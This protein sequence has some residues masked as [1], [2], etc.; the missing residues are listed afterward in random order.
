[1]SI[2]QRI[3]LFSGLILIIATFLVWGVLN[4]LVVEIKK[5]SFLAQEKIEELASL[6]KID[7]EYLRDL[8]SYYNNIKEDLSL[9]K[10]GFLD[11]NQAVDFFMDLENISS[12]TRNRKLEIK[13]GEF[14]YFTLYLFGDFPSLMRFLGWLEN[15]DYLIDVESIQIR[16]LTERDISFGEKDISPGGIKTILQ[17][18][19]HNKI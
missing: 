15:G 1:M 17:I 11:P 4:F 8:E 16:R 5:T 3:F 19:G 18:R 7:L 12:S 6:E 9:V 14:P 2:K 13:A 10:Y